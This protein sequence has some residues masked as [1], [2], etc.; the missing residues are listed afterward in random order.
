MVAISLE[1]I[2]STLRILQ[3]F[4]CLALYSIIWNYLNKKTDGQRIAHDVVVQ[5]N[6][7]FVVTVNSYRSIRKTILAW[8]L[9]GTDMITLTLLIIS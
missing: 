4:S 6:R 1:A 8:S 9:L 2:L 3:V 7:I 5:D